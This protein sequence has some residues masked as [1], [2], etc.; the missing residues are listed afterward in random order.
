MG[1][2][3]YLNEL[4]GNGTSTSQAKEYEG[5]AIGDDLIKKYIPNA[6]IIV[7][8]DLVRYSSIEQVLPKPMDFAFILYQHSKNVGHWILLSRY[9]KTIEYFDSYG[10]HIDKPLDWINDSTEKSLGEAPYLSEL[11]NNASSKYDVIYNAYPFQNTS[12]DI[13]TCGRWDVLRVKTIKE[14]G[15]GLSDFI[16]MLKALKAKTKLSYDN[17]V[18]DLIN[19]I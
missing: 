1:K 13:A 16:D 9:G 11:L 3:K 12:K 17:I 7:N 8:S 2:S 10:G 6:N 18:S 19:G 4:L 15:L 14:D 5:M